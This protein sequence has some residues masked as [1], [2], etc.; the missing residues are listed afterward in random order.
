MTGKRL[1]TTLCWLALT[2]GAQTA[3][4][5]RHSKQQGSVNTRERIPQDHCP[6]MWNTD[7]I[8]CSAMHTHIPETQAS[9]LMLTGLS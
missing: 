7:D 1:A 6:R 5:Q 2:T 4:R 3:G 9:A 8:S